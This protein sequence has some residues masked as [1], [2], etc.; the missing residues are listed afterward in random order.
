[1]EILTAHAALQGAGPDTLRRIMNCTT[2]AAAADIIR[3]EGLEPVWPALAD[4]IR[5]R[6]AIRTFGEIEIAVVVFERDYG[7][8]AQTDNA[9]DMIA[10]AAGK[11]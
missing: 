4:K 1:M 9:A 6:C 11:E 3:E 8:L 2:T 10:R 5:E 7:L